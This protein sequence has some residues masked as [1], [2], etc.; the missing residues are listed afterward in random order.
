MLRRTR[1]ADDQIQHRAFRHARS[2]PD[3]TA[4]EWARCRATRG[5]RHAAAQVG[6]GPAWWHVQV[7]GHERP[8]RAVPAGT[9]FHRLVQEVRPGELLWLGPPAMLA[10]ARPRLLA[11]G[12][13]A[14]R[15]YL[16]AER[17]GSG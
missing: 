12:I 9:V 5:F 2:L 13:P 4:R 15:I 16:P 7:I 11:L 6:D 3:A 14:A 1:G 10:A 8:S 17:P